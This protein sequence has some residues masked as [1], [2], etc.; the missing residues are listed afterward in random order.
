VMGAATAVARDT[1]AVMVT[2]MTIATMAAR[3]AARVE[4][5]LGAAV[6]A[7]PP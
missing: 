6:Q 5:G 4:A 7:A 2:T 1:D 3:A